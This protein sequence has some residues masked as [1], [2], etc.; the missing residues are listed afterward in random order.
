MVSEAS[1]L[2]LDVLSAAL[3]NGRIQ[4][5]IQLSTEIG[6]QLYRLSDVHKVVPLVYDVL[7]H[8]YAF[9]QLDN[10]LKLMFQEKAVAAVQR[11]L[12]Q[13]H[14][15]FTLLE[16]L[17]E[18][19]LCPILVKGVVCSTTYPKPWLRLSVDE[20]LF[21]GNDLYA[22]FCDS[23][24]DKGYKL[25]ESDDEEASMYKEGNPLCVELH[26]QLFPLKQKAYSHLN[27]YFNDAQEQAITMDIQGYKVKTLSPSHHLLFL[28]LHAYK[29]F[30]HSGF[31]LRQIC[32]IA[33]FARTYHAEIHWL[34]LHHV[35]TELRLHDFVAA[36]LNIAQR[37]LNISFQ[38]TPI[39]Y[40]YDMSVNEQP[41]LEDVLESGILGNANLDRM[42]SSNI[43]LQA[44]IQK[45]ASLKS[46]MISSLFP[47]LSYMSANYGYVKALPVL[48]PIAWVHRLFSYLKSENKSRA[49]KSIQVGKERVSLLEYYHII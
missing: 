20:D 8:Y 32:D 19:H 5:K 7:S 35:L 29:H 26:A 21:T 28:I 10:E 44:A 22:A 16:Q 25:L 23:L 47:S 34:Q 42:H 11:Q 27:D 49:L 2:L 33:L 43:T 45:S 9:Q 36:V 1:L 40:I 48:L 41:L 3:G 14:N 37:H 13:T 15:L 12:H 39:P 6:W 31:G 38:E 24:L 18:E 4:S 17:E 46:G 30:L